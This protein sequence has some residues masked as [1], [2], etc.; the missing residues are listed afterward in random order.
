MGR[1]EFVHVLELSEGSPRKTTIKVER[2]GKDVW[3]HQIQGQYNYIEGFNEAWDRGLVESRVFMEMPEEDAYVL[4][5]A[6]LSVLDLRELKGK[7]RKWDELKDWMGEFGF[8]VFIEALR[9]AKEERARR[10]RV[11][12]EV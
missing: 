6:I 10:E 5:D 11:K 8:G 4:A 2:V 3:I 9:E 12:V 7:A 1:R